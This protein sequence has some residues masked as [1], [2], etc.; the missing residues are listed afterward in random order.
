VAVHRP[1]MESITGSGRME[2]RRVNPGV[3]VPG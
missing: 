2:R 1:P 3:L